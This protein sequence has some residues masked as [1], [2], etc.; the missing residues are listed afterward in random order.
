MTNAEKI[1]TFTNKQLAAF[2]LLCDDQDID[3]G[4]TFCDICHGSLEN[5]EC[6]KCLTEWLKKDI[7]A[8]EGLEERGTM[9]RIDAIAKSLE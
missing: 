2:I 4:L 5:F 7:F 1:R 6:S 3:F 8:F 9:A